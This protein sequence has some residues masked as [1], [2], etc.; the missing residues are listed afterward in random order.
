VV[1]KQRGIAV[2]V[3]ALCAALASAQHAAKEGRMRITE[4]GE[5]IVTKEAVAV[6]GFSFDAEGYG[7]LTSGS[8]V[9][10]EW[11]IER[12]GEVMAHCTPMPDEKDGQNGLSTREILQ[13]ADD[14]LP[15]IRDAISRAASDHTFRAITSH[16]REH[17]PTHD[18]RHDVADD[19]EAWQASQKGEG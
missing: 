15:G 8:R 6:K 4:Y 5:V 1:L 7:S 18:D 12:I 10:C 2:I 16:I 17:Y 3:L 19:L 13:H 14:H 11:A 9:A